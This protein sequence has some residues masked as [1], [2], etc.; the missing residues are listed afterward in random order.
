MSPC[1]HCTRGAARWAAWAPAFAGDSVGVGGRGRG[2]DSGPV[3]GYGACF[4]RN[5]V[6][7]Q[8]GGQL[9]VEGAARHGWRGRQGIGGRYRKVGVVPFPSEDEQVVGKEKRAYGK[10]C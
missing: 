10:D 5:E 9:V 6:F 8:E 4:R 1:G 7:L 3:S 2:M